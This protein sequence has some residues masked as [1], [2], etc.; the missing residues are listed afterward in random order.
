LAGHL[1]PRAIDVV[2]AQA[3]LANPCI[4]ALCAPTLVTIWTSLIRGARWAW[5]AFAGTLLPLQAFGFISDAFLG[6][7]NFVVNIVSSG[8]LLVALVL[9]G[10]G[11]LVGRN[12]QPSRRLSFRSTI[13]AQPTRR[14]PNKQESL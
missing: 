7:R 3:A 1:D 11:L 6:H 12:R 9:S 10:F 5:L 14:P 13:R 8:L 2:N 4:V